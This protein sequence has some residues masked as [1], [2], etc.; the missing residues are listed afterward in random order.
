MVA[1]QGVST[2][3]PGSWD[4]AP[5]L[6]PDA[7]LWRKIPFAAWSKGLKSLGCSQDI[8]GGGSFGGAAP[9]L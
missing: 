4:P 9:R 7:P 8:A 5:F 1:S 2:F 6:I 3:P